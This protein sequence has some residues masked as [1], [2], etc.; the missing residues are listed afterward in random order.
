[1][2]RFARDELIELLA[3]DIE[4]RPEAPGPDAL[5]PFVRGASLDVRSL[6]IELDPAG[7]AVAEAFVAAEQV[8]CASIGWALEGENGL[9]LRITAA[10][11]QLKVL[12]GLVPAGIEIENIQ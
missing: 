7:R 8:C 10:Q 6:F 2:S 3:C 5:A 11:P 4:S 9:R 12:A 1:M